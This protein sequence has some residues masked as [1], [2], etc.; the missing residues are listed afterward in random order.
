M[1]DIVDIASRTP[2]YSVTDTKNPHLNGAYRFLAECSLCHAQV[3]GPSVDVGDIMVEHLKDRHFADA[4]ATPD[5]AHPQQPLVVEEPVKTFV[6]VPPAAKPPIAVP[7]V[8][9]VVGS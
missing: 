3:R 9:P 8:P 5:S 1:P 2:N 4:V 6:I 7:P